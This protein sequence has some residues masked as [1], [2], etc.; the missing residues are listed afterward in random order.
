MCEIKS[1]N[2]NICLHHVFSS[3]FSLDLW[4]TTRKH[5]LKVR[6]CSP[7]FLITIPHILGDCVCKIRQTT[8]A[9]GLAARRRARRRRRP[10]AR[11]CFCS[12]GLVAAPRTRAAGRAGAGQAA[13]PR[14]C[15]SPACAR[16]VWGQ[17]LASGVFAERGRLQNKPHERCQTPKTATKTTSC[18]A[19][20]NWRETRARTKTKG[21]L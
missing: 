4:M 21:W 16:G 7:G 8:S 11:L 12:A 17:G 6:H 13:V 19:W 9:A 15:C 10:H 20:R 2:Y 1:S 3:G 14:R 18:T 5:L